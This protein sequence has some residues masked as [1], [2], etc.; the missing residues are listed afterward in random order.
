MQRIRDW[1]E[2]STFSLEKK[3]PIVV[4]VDQ[5]DCPYCHQVEN[6]FIAALL[7]DDQW[8]EKAIFGKIS[9]DAG[10]TII[11]HTGQS[12]ST[13]A[14]LSSYQPDFTPT[15]LYLDKDLQS[16]SDPLIGLSTPDY[17][18]YYLEQGIQAALEELRGSAN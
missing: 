16:L 8:A 12:V 10:E 11:D 13:R 14:F 17:Y 9:I 6:E 15:I 18:G 3:T 2:V 5:E 7:A 1:R 4:M